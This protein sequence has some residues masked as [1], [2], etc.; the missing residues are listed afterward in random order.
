VAGRVERGR[1]LLDL[2]CVPAGADP[3]VAAAVLAVAGSA[4]GER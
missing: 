3:D 2:R 1:L 4:P